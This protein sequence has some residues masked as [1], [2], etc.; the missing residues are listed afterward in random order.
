MG[1]DM[2]YW[3]ADGDRLKFRCPHAVGKVDCPLGIAACSDSNYGMVVK[4]SITE[5]V[6]RYANPHRNTRGWT[7]L[8]NE[9]TS[10]ER[11]NSRL[12]ENLTVND[13]HIRGIQKV[14]TYAYL[15]TIVLLASALAMNAI[16]NALKQH[17]RTGFLTLCYRHGNVQTYT[18]QTK[19]VN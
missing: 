17:N 7:A 16:A 8:Y 6:R 14:T 12:K 3:G 9:R 10:V 18:E 5:D 15:N 11:C 4:T 1:Y 19:N 2:V 13:V